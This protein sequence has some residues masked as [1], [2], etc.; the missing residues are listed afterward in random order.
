MSNLNFHDNNIVTVKS[1]GTG[2]VT[3]N[4]RSNSSGL[5]D[6]SEDI[7][8]ILVNLANNHESYD[9]NT[10]TELLRTELTTKLL[11][12]SDFKDDGKP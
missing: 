3:I 12:D 1:L 5:E 4:Q 7:R 11:D 9:E 10:K 8:L 2:N 6:V